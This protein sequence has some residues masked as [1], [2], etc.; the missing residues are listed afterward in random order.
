MSCWGENG[1]KQATAS[2]GTYEEVGGGVVHACGLK[3]D[4][5]IACWGSNTLNR[6]ASPPGVFKAIDVNQLHSCAL[7]KDGSI[8][9]W[10]WADQGS[11]IPESCGN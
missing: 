7:G 6:T 3:T 10:G 1:A 8:S 2:P 5:T 4:G 11:T 9:C